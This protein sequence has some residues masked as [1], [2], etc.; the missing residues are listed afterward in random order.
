MN[1]GTRTPTRKYQ[2]GLEPLLIGYVQESL[3]RSRSSAQLMGTI[4]K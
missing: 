1:C 4:P 2:K 3:F